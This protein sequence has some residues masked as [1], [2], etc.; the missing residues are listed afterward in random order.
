LRFL[1]SLVQA[2]TSLP[3][4]TAIVTFILTT[5][6]LVLS[7]ARVVLNRSML[8]P[9][10]I[11]LAHNKCL[12]T[13]RSPQ[14]EKKLVQATPHLYSVLDKV[15]AEILNSGSSNSNSVFIACSAALRQFKLQDKYDT[16]FIL[17]EAYIRTRKA[18]DAG[19]EITNYWAWIRSTNFNIIRELNRA[20]TKNR[21]RTDGL[22]VDS[23][24]THEA[25]SWTDDE[26]ETAEQQRM[27]RAFATLSP[28]EQAILQLKV[29]KGLRWA[30]VQSALI[31]S[32]FESINPNLLS[33]KKRRAL[34]KLK[35]HF[36]AY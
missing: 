17:N 20:E 15:F 4:L 7:K 36:A 30:E 12:E 28:L 29:V 2:E 16:A 13:S 5:Y 35:E 22:D 8:K 24:P 25:D 3:N 10:R 18:L 21:Q 32:G 1:A 23:L 14:S 27:R 11:T 19:M 26:I 31:T 9:L 6:V 34:Q 33:Q